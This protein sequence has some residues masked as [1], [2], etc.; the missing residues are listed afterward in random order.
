[1]DQIVN[2][3]A[4]IRFMLGGQID[5]P[6]VIRI[7]IGGTENTAAQHSQS[8]EAWF[9]HVPGLTVVYP[10]TSYQAKGMFLTALA[11]PN[12]VTFFWNR[13]R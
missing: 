12:P 3:A 8:L 1:M 4:K 6:L 11:E 10:A 9:T 2:Q 7:H 5:V 13:D